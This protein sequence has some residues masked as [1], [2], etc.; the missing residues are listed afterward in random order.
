MKYTYTLLKQ[1]GAT[2]SLGEFDKEMDY[3]E[4]RKILNCQMLEIIPEAYHQK[5]WVKRGRLLWGDEEGR[6]NSNNHRNPHTKVLVDDLGNEWDCVGN[7]LL[8]E[9]KE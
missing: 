6:F 2:E 7:L 4:V 8:Q 5:E 9:G 1:D 3:L